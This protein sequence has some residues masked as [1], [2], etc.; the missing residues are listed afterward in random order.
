MREPSAQGRAVPAS[1]VSRRGQQE[2]QYES[3]YWASGTYSRTPDKLAPRRSGQ[4]PPALRYSRW[5]AASRW[6]ELMAPPLSSASTV[7]CKT[8]L[9][10]WAPVRV[11]RVATSRSK[12]DSTACCGGRWLFHIAHRSLASGGRNST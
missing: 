1:P 10:I 8:A 11:Q 7:A 5:T 2:Q 4:T 6:L 3:Q 9:R 12:E